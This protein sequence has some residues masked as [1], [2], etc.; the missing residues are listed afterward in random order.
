MKKVI[1][2]VH[3]GVIERPIDEVRA[4]FRDFVYHSKQEVHPGI[5]FTVYHQDAA[6]A[7]FR[8]DVRILGMLQSDE[9][10]ATNNPDGSLSTI[11][12]D[13]PNKG[14]EIVV[15][16]EKI[17]ERKTLV[18]GRFVIPV[19]GFKALIAP[20][21]EK[22]AKKIAAGVL[23]DDRRDLERGRYARYLK[24]GEITGS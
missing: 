14:F 21:F 2:F 7:R 12:T 18:K 15:A 10:V 11:V 20:L 9:L 1:D 23:E 22:A 16:C 6:G 17:D 19:T 8:Q 24:T 3:S 5:K 4:Q 13:G